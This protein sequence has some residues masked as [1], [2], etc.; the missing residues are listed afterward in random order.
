MTCEGNMVCE[1]SE[2][3]TQ[4]KNG[5]FFQLNIVMG[6]IVLYSVVGL[7][8][9]TIFKQFLE[10][11]VDEDSLIGLAIF[12]GVLWPLALAVMVLY[13][14]VLWLVRLI[15]LPFI[16]ATKQ[17]LKVVENKLTSK[18]DECCNPRNNSKKVSKED[19]KAIKVG[20]LVKG[21]KGNP[22]NYKYL[23]EDSISRVLNINEKG[24]MDLK[25]VD[26]KDPEIYEK[27]FGEVFHAPV[28]NFVLHKKSR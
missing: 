21:V 19:K 12:G 8:V 2:I 4:F 25:L 9:G 15:V 18:I 20:D 10:N 27:K 17:D 6:W 13:Y 3:G 5:P 28:R 1:F 16:A 11:K 26:H 23:T 14:P 24:I 7:A 22:D